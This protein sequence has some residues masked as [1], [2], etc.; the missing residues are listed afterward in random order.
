MCFMFSEFQQIFVLKTL[1]FILYKKEKPFSYAILWE[2]ALKMFPTGLYAFGGS[3]SLTSLLNNCF[4]FLKG[5]LM[6]KAADMIPC[7]W[8]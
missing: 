5:I 8:L 2:L 7:F 1:F 6:E 3:G 4:K